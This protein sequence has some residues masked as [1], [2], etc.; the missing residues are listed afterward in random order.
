MFPVDEIMVDGVVVDDAEAEC[1]RDLGPVTGRVE[2]TVRMD[3][4]AFGGS[5]MGREG[6]AL[7]AVGGSL[8]NALLVA[9]GGCCLGQVAL[10]ALGP[11][12]NGDILLGGNGAA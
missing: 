2:D 10:R 6:I 4:G 12:G 9:A 5:R 7:E 1:S 3:L 8:G 11:V